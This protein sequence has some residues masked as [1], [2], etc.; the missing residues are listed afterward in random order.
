MLFLFEQPDQM[1]CLPQKLLTLQIVCQVSSIAVL[2]EETNRE[3]KT[4]LW[5]QYR[6]I[7]NYVEARGLD[8]WWAAVGGRS[9]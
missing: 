8:I 2:E 5:N 1:M 7:K 3:N 4:Q 6:T 9:V